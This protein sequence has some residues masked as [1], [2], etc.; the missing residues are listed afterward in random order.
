MANHKKRI[1]N[2]KDLGSFTIISNSSFDSGGDRASLLFTIKKDFTLE[3]QKIRLYINNMHLDGRGWAKAPEDISDF[4]LD[5]AEI[6]T[7]R[8][9]ET[10]K[11]EYQEYNISAVIEPRPMTADEIHSPEEVKDFLRTIT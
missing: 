2:L 11:N 3:E 9:L 6:I 8:K 1:I 10:G 4:L 7:K 5:C